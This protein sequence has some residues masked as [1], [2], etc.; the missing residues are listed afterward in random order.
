M[1]LFQDIR[2]RPDAAAVDADPVVKALANPVMTA[3]ENHGVP[4]LAGEKHG[5]LTAPAALETRGD[6]RPRCRRVAMAG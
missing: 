3:L 4:V 6:L 1:A 5:A 2:T